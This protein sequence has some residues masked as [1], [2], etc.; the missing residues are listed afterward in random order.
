MASVPN[1][2]QALKFLF[3][4]FKQISFAYKHP[5]CSLAGFLFTLFDESKQFR[6]LI[7]RQAFI[8]K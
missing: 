7:S 1:A 5:A 8:P 3:L 2:L 6:I 4:S